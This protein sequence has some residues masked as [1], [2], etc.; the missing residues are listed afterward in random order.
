MISILED[1]EGDV[2]TYTVKPG[3]SLGK[4]AVENKT[5]TRTIKKLNGLEGDTIYVG[6]KLKLPASR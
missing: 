3:D 6:Q 5:N 2:F 4:I 1:E